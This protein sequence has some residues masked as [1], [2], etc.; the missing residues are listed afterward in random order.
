[1]EYLPKA[2]EKRIQEIQQKVRQEIRQEV[3]NALIADYMEEGFSTEKILGKLEKRFSLA[4]E[5]ARNCLE[6]SAS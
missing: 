4:P 2:V 6:R 3:I 1:E 5:E